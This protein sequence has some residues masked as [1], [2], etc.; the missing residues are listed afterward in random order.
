M[1]V[2]NATLKELIQ[3]ER[4][5]RV[6]IW[7]RQYAWRH[8]QHWQLWQDLLEQYGHFQADASADGAGHFLGSFVL[9]P[10]TPT[11][12]GAQTFLVIDGQQR[13][14]TLM[15]V[16]CALR[17]VAAEQSPE[18]VNRF[19]KLYLINE[20][21]TGDGHFRLQPTEEDSA[22]LGRASCASPTM[23]HAT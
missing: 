11:A 15:L 22:A 6:P 23:A 7:Q 3:G 16:L 12:S 8:P 2:Q 9:S 19:D 13:L 4:Q 20:F 21:Q 17:D 18:A 1:H 5:F 14:T 10:V